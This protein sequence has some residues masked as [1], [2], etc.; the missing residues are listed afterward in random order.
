MWETRTFNFSF[1]P[2]SCCLRTWDMISG[3]LAAM[4][5][6]EV[7]LQVEAQ[8]RMAESRN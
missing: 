5:D 7:T 1:F 4:L 2:S 3:A 6:H 8:A